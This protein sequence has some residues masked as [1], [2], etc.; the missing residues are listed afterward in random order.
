MS[1]Q[2]DTK[3]K[4]LENKFSKV[5]AISGKKKMGDFAMECRIS[6][7]TLSKA[8]ERSSLSDDIVDKIYDR[9]K[10][11]KGYWEDGKEPI[12]DKNPTPAIKSTDNNE[13]AQDTIYK[14][15]VEANTDYRLVPKIILD[16]Y[17]I[18]P[19]QEAEDRR[20]MLTIITKAK[21][22]LIAKSDV[23]INKYETL[24]S[25]YEA[26]IDELEATVEKYRAEAESLRSQLMSKVS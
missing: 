3:Y 11:R 16:Q 4:D 24:V 8:L 9:F 19:K 17:H 13:M 7:G 18:V 20:E 12:L 26:D 5:L 22:D 15:L 14:D 6:P 23:I 21:D 1:R 10:V 2:V 25:K